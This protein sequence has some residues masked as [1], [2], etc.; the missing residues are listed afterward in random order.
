M[1]TLIPGPAG[2]PLLGNVNDIDPD[3]PIKSLMDIADKYGPIYSLSMLGRRRV[4]VSSVELMNEIC[5]ER[6]FGKVV[7][8]ALGE[9]RNLTGD[10]L[11]TA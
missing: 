8:A 3:V 7:T 5:D 6:R 11:F 1:S 10:G 2:W 9:V 4:V